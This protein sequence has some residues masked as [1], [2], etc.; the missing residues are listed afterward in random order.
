M[1][2]QPKVCESKKR[3]QRVIGV[4]DIKGN[5][6]RSVSLEPASPAVKINQLK[7]L[8]SRWTSLS[9]LTLKPGPGIVTKF[10]LAGFTDTITS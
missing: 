1:A 6:F 5:R 4:L 2:G 3:F 10:R 8:I 9:Y 7:Q